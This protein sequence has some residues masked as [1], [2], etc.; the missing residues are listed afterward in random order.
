MPLCQELLRVHASARLQFRDRTREN[1]YS[2]QD[3][4]R[5]EEDMIVKTNVFCCFC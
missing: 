3:S 1:M 4:F 5:D 2:I